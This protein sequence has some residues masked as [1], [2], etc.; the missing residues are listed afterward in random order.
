MILYLNVQADASAT[1]SA[2][3]Y[4]YDYKARGVGQVSFAVLIG[5]SV[6]SVHDA[7]HYTSLFSPT[8]FYASTI[9]WR[10]VSLSDHMKSCSLAIVYPSL[11]PAPA[12]FFS[13]CS[14]FCLLPL[15]LCRLMAWSVC[16]F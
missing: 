6:P 10:M 3:F 7:P 15:S 9:R 2:I 16:C 4:F 11:P 8:L 14:T 1:C 5:C 13:L 12:V